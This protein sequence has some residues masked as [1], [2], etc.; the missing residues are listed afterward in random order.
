MWYK[1]YDHIKQCQTG[2]KF[3]RIIKDKIVP[4]QIMRVT[5]HELGHYTYED[6]LKGIH[7]GSAFGGS[8]FKTQEECEEELRR[9]QNVREKRRLMKEHE[10]ELNEKLNIK[11]HYIIK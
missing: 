8:L 1:E 2:D 5:H 4:V 6:D 7:T 11:D 3:Y 10:S 9:R